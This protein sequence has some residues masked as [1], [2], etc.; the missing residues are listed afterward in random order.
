MSAVNTITTLGTL[1]AP[2][3]A[4]DLHRAGPW[5]AAWRVSDLAYRA[6]G[7]RRV[8]CLAMATSPEAALEELAVRMTCAA[9]H[10][11]DYRCRPAADEQER[12]MAA[13]LL[14]ALADLAGEHCEHCPET[15]VCVV[16]E[17]AP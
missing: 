15:G 5:V 6:Q 13:A 14:T 2:D 7:K 12:E 9:S 1:L 10:E 4:L 17:V 11:A 3:G 8:A 16:C